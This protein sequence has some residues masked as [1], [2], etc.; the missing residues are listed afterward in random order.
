MAIA[1]TLRE[2]Y[3][4][5]VDQVLE[6]DKDGNPTRTQTVP[7]F[8]GGVIA[9]GDSDFNTL[10]ALEEGGGT[11]VVDEVARP[12]LV[13]ALDAFPALKRTGVHAEP[14][15]T[16]DYNSRTVADLRDELERRAITGAGN[17]NKADLVAALEAFDARVA[18][19]DSPAAGTN[20]GELAVDDGDAA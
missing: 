9:V 14:A 6:T 16:A 20:V 17:L 7:V 8:Q 19:G 15:V 11:I 18:A 1:Y 5:T 3:A 2:D 13:Q 12:E 4:G 10:E